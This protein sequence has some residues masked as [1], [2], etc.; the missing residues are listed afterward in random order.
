M[1]LVIKHITLIILTLS[2]VAICY[3][4][5]LLPQQSNYHNNPA[6]SLK[7]AHLKDKGIV[8]PEFRLQHLNQEITLDDFKGHW[9]LIFFGYT[10]CPDICPFA[11]Q[12]MEYTYKILE[13]EDKH[14]NL[15]VFFISVDPE[16]DNL[17]HLDQYLTYFHKDFKGITG[18][19]EQIKQLAKALNIFYIRQPNS[20]NENNYIIDHSANMLI[21]NPE[22]EHIADFYPP[23]H[24][25]IMAGDLQYL[26]TPGNI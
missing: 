26:F 23:H 7:E 1:Q 3:Q 22:G 18:E 14:Q 4:I 13:K 5:A 15:Q 12:A 19:P 16:R 10:Y 11:L 21:I 17:K 2:V 8:L 24:P 25:E 20:K 9:N 6:L